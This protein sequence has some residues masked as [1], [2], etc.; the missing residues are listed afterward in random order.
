MFPNVNEREMLKIFNICQGKTA[1]CDL[2]LKDSEKFY[3]KS[4][5]GEICCYSCFKPTQVVN[6][7]N[8]N[9]QIDNRNGERHTNGSNHKTSGLDNLENIQSNN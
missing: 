2:C 3:L 8:L 1:L 6:N 5:E 7:Q 9:G 4:K